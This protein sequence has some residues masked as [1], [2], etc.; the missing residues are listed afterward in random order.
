MRR[1][2]SEARMPLK[3]FTPLK[4]DSEVEIELQLRKDAN[5]NACT[6]QSLTKY[7]AKT[8]GSK[9][10]M[11]LNWGWLVLIIELAAPRIC[12]ASMSTFMT[13][14]LPPETKRLKRRSLPVASILIARSVSKIHL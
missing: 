14:R 13:R 3:S 12:A 9:V 11:P 4:R 2:S 7:V 6:P 1:K 10:V 8:A 5:R